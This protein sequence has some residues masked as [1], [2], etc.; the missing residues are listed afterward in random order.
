M[1]WPSNE[2]GV[3]CQLISLFQNWL[4]NPRSTQHS[5]LGTQH[6]ARNQQT[7]YMLLYL[8]SSSW[9]ILIRPSLTLAGTWLRL[10]VTHS[11][12][13]VSDVTANQS[14]YQLHGY[15]SIIHYETHYTI[16]KLPSHTSRNPSDALHTN[17]QI[18]E[19]KRQLPKNQVV[20]YK[21]NNNENIGL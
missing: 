13:P 1:W 15:H 4:N 14:R 12:D 3:I 17:G 21:L 11:E 6:S 20:C 16:L 8:P 9:C 7:E 18:V 10:P 2:L 5:A 19:K